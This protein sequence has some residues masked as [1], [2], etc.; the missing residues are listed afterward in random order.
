MVKHGVR[1]LQSAG[2]RVL[3][4]PGWSSRTGV[5]AGSAEER[6][7]DIVGLLENPDIDVILG[8]WG[9]KGCLE[10]AMSDDL[11][12]AKVSGAKAFVGFSDVGLLACALSELAGLR[13]YY[14]LNVVG[15]L[16]E[17]PHFIERIQSICKGG[18][19]FTVQE[20]AI[21][22][23]IDRGTCT[24]HL[25]GGNLETLMP[26]LAT[27]ILVPKFDKIILFWEAAYCDLPTIRSYMVALRKVSFYDRIV[28]M[29]IGHM[30]AAPNR[31]RYQAVGRWRAIK[32][33]FADDKFTVVYAPVFG[34]TGQ[35]NE[36]I[37]IGKGAT[38]G[39]NR[40]G[41]QGRGSATIHIKDTV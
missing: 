20:R 40:Q 28:G 5:V 16:S 3:L 25:Y 13:C 12:S 1:V 7:K 2:I 29:W 34:H 38:I 35:N 4:A 23:C 11:Y 39:I 26:A 9:G 17:T 33:V 32:D 10:L 24:G 15:K 30:G 41:R 22:G 21:E 14:G 19:T 27:N 8:S 36:P 18:S 37:A 31:D 6:I